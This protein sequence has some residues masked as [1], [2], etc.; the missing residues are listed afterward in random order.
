M[1]FNIFFKNNKVAENLSSFNLSI[2]AIL[3][4]FCYSK[5]ILMLVIMN[6]I[7]GLN[8]DIGKVN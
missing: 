4:I 3:S 2:A 8:L 7:H 1:L 6:F 5:L